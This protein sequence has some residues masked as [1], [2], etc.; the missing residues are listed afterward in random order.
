MSLSADEL[1]KAMWATMGPQNDAEGNPL[2]IPKQIVNRAKGIVEAFKLTTVSH[3]LVTANGLPGAPITNGAANGG[4]LAGLTAGP[5]N[6]RMGDIPAGMK[7]SNAALMTYLATGTV[8]FDSGSITGTCSATPT[9]PGP[10]VAGAGNGGYLVGLT[11][12]ACVSALKGQGLKLGPDSEDFYGAIVDYLLE[13]LEVT[14]AP[15]SVV[16]TFP[17]GGGA[18]IGGLAS[19]GVI[20]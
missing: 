1:A 4:V 19:G 15:G 18:L 5:V 8:T 2:E 14:Y 13:N 20:S 9:S 6:A 3:A 17:S 12:S 11:G 7:Q 10:L 16:G